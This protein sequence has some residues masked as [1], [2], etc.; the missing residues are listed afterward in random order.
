MR[1]GKDATAWLRQRADELEAR[2]REIRL[3]I[4]GI[5]MI[6]AAQLDRGL[7]GEL[8]AQL[9]AAISALC[10]RLRDPRPGGLTASR[11]TWCQLQ[12]D[13]LFATLDLLTDAVAQRADARIG[14]LLAGAEVL[15]R[16]ALDARV[17]GY[18]PPAPLCYL[19]RGRGG[20]IRRARTQLA[21]G[22]ILPVALIRV[23]LHSLATRL[24]TVLHE[25]GHQLAVDLA[26]LGEA[27]RLIERTSAGALGLPPLAALWRSWTGELL[28]DAWSV[29]AGGGLLALD[30]LQR[31]L[32]AMPAPLAYAFSPGAPHPPGMVRAR[33]T[34]ELARVVD[35]APDPLLEQLDR[36]WSETYASVPLP[37]ARRALVE[38]LERAAPAVA[39]A[40]AH[41]RFAGLGGQTLAGAA[42]SARV[43]GRRIAGL[44]PLASSEA[45]QLAALDPVVAIAVLCRARL[46]TSISPRAAESAS[47]RLLDSLAAR[48]DDAPTAASF[49]PSPRR[50]LVA[51]RSRGQP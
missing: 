28:A 32:A 17:P 31:L 15:A 38:R 13:G 20:E 4:A 9:R 2:L 44:A 47:L 19:D 25:A 39:A 26:L 35:P 7:V 5:P 3:P 24:S 42:G 49:H 43:S 16:A 30:G 34:L 11:L 41:H 45:P 14:P 33:F 27:A 48:R 8:G 6:P 12:A 23:G 22:V 40:L 46:A 1:A 36:R 21:G 37:P 10:R 50:A 29:C 18:R 51:R